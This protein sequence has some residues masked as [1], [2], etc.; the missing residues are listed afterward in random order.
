MDTTEPCSRRSL[1]RG[2]LGV[3]AGVAAGLVSAAAPIRASTGDPL[4]VGRSDNAADKPTHLD[5][6]GQ[7]YPAFG[8]DGSGIAIQGRTPGTG[9]AIVGFTPGSGTGVL[10]NSMTG[11]GVVGIVYDSGDGVVGEAQGGSGAG[12]RGTS[13]SGRGAVVSG[14]LAQLRLVPS[15]ASTHPASGQAG[16]LFLDRRKRLWLCKGGTSWARIA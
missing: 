10:G 9:N 5:V 13:K 16:D 11:R 3:I 14:G 2:G 7:E 8:V 15:T 1:I 12:L 4:L 6:S